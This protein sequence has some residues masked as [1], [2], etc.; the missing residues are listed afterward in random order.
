MLIAIN[1]DFLFDFPIPTRSI[2]RTAFLCKALADFVQQCSQVVAE[3][4]GFASGGPPTADDAFSPSILATLPASP[5]SSSKFAPLCAHSIP[6]AT[7]ASRS[8]PAC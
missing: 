8:S 5:A 6:P 1:R 2:A 4:V 7:A 3:V